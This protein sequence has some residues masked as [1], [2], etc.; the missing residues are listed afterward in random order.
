MKTD[1]DRRE[2]PVSERNI[3]SF[4]RMAS[5]GSGALMLFRAV[6]G[7]SLVKGATAG[8]MLYRGITGHCPVTDF[9]EKKAF[10]TSGNYGGAAHVD[11]EP[12]MRKRDDEPLAEAAFIPQA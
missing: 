6:R 4:E 3:S 2:T 7:K 11:E 12:V 9:L 1:K 10:G 5:V 8:Y